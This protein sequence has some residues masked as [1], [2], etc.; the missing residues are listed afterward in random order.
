MK[1]KKINNKEIPKNKEKPLK[2][3]GNFLYFDSK[4]LNGRIYKKEIAEEILEQ[5]NKMK[6][7]SPVLGELGYPE[8]NSFMEIDLSNVSHEVEEIHLDE[9]NKSIAG[10]IKILD[11]PKGKIVKELL[12]S[13]NQISLYCRP[14]GTGNINEN[15]EIENFKI[16]SFDLVSGPNAFENI[17]KEDYVKLIEN[18]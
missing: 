11:T 18:D 16:L 9:K 8:K 2:L 13:D 10:T 17:V 5:F 6:K 3:A 12:Q 15:G 4:N 1:N 14:R 7:E